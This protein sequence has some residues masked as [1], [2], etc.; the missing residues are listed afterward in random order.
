MQCPRENSKNLTWP[1]RQHD[2]IGHGRNS[3]LCETCLCP[4]GRYDAVC[5]SDESEATVKILE[6][7]SHYSNTIYTV[8]IELYKSH[9]DFYRE[10]LKVEMGLGKEE[11]L[12][13]KE[14]LRWLVGVVSGCGIIYNR[15]VQVFLMFSWAAQGRGEVNS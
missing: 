3:R 7:H 9:C 6:A 5:D 8:I 2:F 1:S 12:A 14:M 4:Q 13:D 10:L 11:E 15:T